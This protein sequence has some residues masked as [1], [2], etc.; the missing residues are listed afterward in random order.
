MKVDLHTHTTA[1]DGQL[2]PEA[3]V[4]KAVKDKVE[5]LAITDHDTLNGYHRALDVAKQSGIRLVSG[6]EFSS[7]WLAYSV[8]IVGLNFDVEHSAIKNGIEAQQQ[9][10]WLRAKKIAQLLEEQGIAG[11][12]EG[13][14][15]FSGG[16]PPGRPHFARFMVEQKVVPDMNSAFKRYLSD[17][18]M[19][20]LIE[21]WAS[22]PEVIDWIHQAGG[23]AVL[24]HPT[25]NKKMKWKQ[26]RRLARV[27]K[28]AGGDAIELI[29]N[30]QVQPDIRR[31]VDK[32]VV[33]YAMQGSGGS[34]YHGAGGGELGRDIEFPVGCEPVWANWSLTALT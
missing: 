29:T 20:G 31:R 18:K 33:D 10:R 12:E 25:Q 15:R 2:A 17:L 26:I 6:I 13:A 21:G 28:D 23:V 7:Y 8:H 1:S 9:Q 4:A 16:H 5:L 27:F 24:A 22:I 14:L 3:L 32:L 11:T 34:D 30:D 19:K